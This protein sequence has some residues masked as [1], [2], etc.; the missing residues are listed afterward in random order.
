MTLWAQQAEDNREILE[1]NVTNGAITVRIREH[2]GHLRSF[3]GELG[4]LLE[5]AEQ[6]P[7]RD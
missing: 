6:K 4:R 5:K 3:W 1:V 7:E 2:I